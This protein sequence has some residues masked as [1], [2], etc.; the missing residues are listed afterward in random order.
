MTDFRFMRIIFKKLVVVNV[1]AG[2]QVV[3]NSLMFLSYRNH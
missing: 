2:N 3:I 1:P